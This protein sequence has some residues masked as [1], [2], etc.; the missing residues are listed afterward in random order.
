MIQKP[1]YEN[2]ANKLNG[3]FFKMYSASTTT[4][5]DFCE[6]DFTSVSFDLDNVNEE[7]MNASLGTG[8]DLIPGRLW[9][10]LQVLFPFMY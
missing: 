8:I 7:L 9:D 5:L 1:R 2:F 3:F 10:I 4:D 6:Q